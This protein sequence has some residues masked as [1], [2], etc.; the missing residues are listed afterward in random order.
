MSFEEAVEAVLRHEGGYVNDPSDPGGAT[1]FG[2][3]SRSYPHLNIQDLTREQA[4]AEYRRIWIAGPYEDLADPIGMKLFDIAINMG[5]RAA[6]AC[7]QRACRACGAD[8]Q[9]D[10]VVGPRTIDAAAAAGQMRLLPAL[11]SEAACHY[12]M[13]CE[14][15]PRLARFRNGW[16]ARAYS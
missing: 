12:R 1:K 4:I 7:L 14:T 2:I 5:S 8:V 3:S 15:N 9:E 13:I 6:A 11:R 10:G 16:L